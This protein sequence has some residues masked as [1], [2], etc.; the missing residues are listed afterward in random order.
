MITKKETSYQDKSLALFDAWFSENYTSI[1]NKVLPYTIY[2]ELLTPTLEDAF[3]DAY[4]LARNEVL[5]TNET[6]FELIFIAAYKRT[7]KR[8]FLMATSK[9]N[10]EIRPKDLFWAFLRA[11]DDN[12]RLTENARKEKRLEL[13]EIMNKWAYVTFSADE[14][15]LFRLY[16]KNGFSQDD[17]ADY[18]GVSQ[19]AIS[20]RIGHMKT[21]L[22]ARF[23]GDFMNLL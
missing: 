22:C 7:Y 20:K 2:G 18:Y 4:L 1:K 9:E 10:K 19:M 21:M 12:D 14:Y 16:F 17:L 11:D 5:G 15:Q 8:L 3:H 13:I 23:E 6:E